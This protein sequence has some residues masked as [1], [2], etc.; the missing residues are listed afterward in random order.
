MAKDGKKAADASTTY[1]ILLYD[2]TDAN[3]NGAV[4]IAGF[5]NKAVAEAHAG[6]TFDETYATALP[7]IKFME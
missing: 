6:V 2:V 5:I 4:V 3:P 7:M 1:G